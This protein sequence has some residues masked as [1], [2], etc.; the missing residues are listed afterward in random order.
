MEHIW[1]FIGC[2]VVK[3]HDDF[4][5]LIPNDN[6]VF[7]SSISLAGWFAIEGQDLERCAMDMKWMR[8]SL[9]CYSPDFN[10]TFFDVFIDIHHIH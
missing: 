3:A 6:R 10:F 2:F 9:A 4:G 5:H 7:P 8:H 1:K